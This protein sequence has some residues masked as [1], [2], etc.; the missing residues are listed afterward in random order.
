VASREPTLSVTNAWDPEADLLTY[1]Y[2]VATDEAM[3]QIVTSVTGV[4]EGLGVSGWTVPVSLDENG[5]YYW[6][7]RASDGENLSPWS[8][9]IS[10]MVD[11]VNES[12]SVPVPLRPEDGAEVAT[13]TPELAVG[14]ASDPEGD[15]VS[16]LFEVDV[17]ASFDSPALQASPELPGA[18]EVGW[19]PEP[20]SDNTLHYWRAAAGDGNTLSPW[21]VGSFFVNLANDPPGVPVPLAPA[22]GQVV[23][24]ATPTLRV[25]NADD[26]DRDVLSYEFLVPRVWPRPSGRYPSLSPRTRRSSGAPGRTT[27]R[28]TE[29]GARP[30][31]SESTPCP[32][33]PRRRGSSRRSKAPFSTSPA[34]SWWSRTPRAPRAWRS[35]MPSSCMRWLPTEP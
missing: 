35:A 2:R 26:L 32:I 14:G 19:I 27:A 9:P 17:V 4:A 21:V 1:E 25:R 31:A 11:T 7:V 24:T 29:P 16:Y 10:F 33:R 6:S 23:T 3:T 15:P 13:L 8:Q 20:L 5:I 34:P 12:P 22:D 18:T 28:P 30:A